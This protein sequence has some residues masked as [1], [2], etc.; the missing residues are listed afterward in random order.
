MG[1]N[2]IKLLES[3]SLDAKKTKQILEENNMKGITHLLVYSF[4]Y[5]LCDGDEHKIQVLLNSVI[6]LFTDDTSIHKKWRID[7]PTE[8]G[9]YVVLTSDR[10]IMKAYFHKITNSFDVK[11]VVGWMTLSEFKKL[12]IGGNK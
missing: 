12:N 7:L 10:T 5:E 1:N 4:V 3:V 6:E 2:I 11:G 8:A 9:M